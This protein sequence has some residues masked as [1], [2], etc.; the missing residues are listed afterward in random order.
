[1]RLLQSITE[2]VTVGR[3]IINTVRVEAPRAQTQT[4]KPWW[5]QAVEIVRLRQGVGKLDPDEYYQYGLY[6]DRRFTWE[7]KRQFFGRRM[8][9]GLIPILREGWWLGLANDKVI[10]YAFLKGMG[11][12]I[13]EPVA[14]YH[15]WRSCGVTPMLRTPAALADFIRQHRQPFV[16]KP[17][18]GMSGR[19]VSAVREY[20]ATR[21]SVILTNGSAS[22][23]D[24][25]V[26]SL[27]AARDQGGM[28]L[29]E[30]L[31]PHPAIQ[32]RCGERLCTVRLITIV[33]RDG[34]RVLTT[35]WKIATGPSMTDNY[36]RGVNSNLVGPIDLATG[37][38]G[39]TCTGVGHELRYVEQHPDTGKS[40]PGFTLPD[41]QAAVDLCLTATAAI[42][43]LPL[44]AW[45]VALTS[46]GPVL[47]EVNVNGGMTLPQVCVGEGI[48][49]GDFATFLAKFGFPDRH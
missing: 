28:L 33:D 36:C 19:D 12:P 25:F 4:G 14:V 17:V 30:L 20:D 3:E 38:V 8:E 43:K 6:D 9:N 37:V 48:F 21:D 40:L 26:R 1:M 47:L 5:T 45:D 49:R 10:A 29:Q 13:P 42:P 11:F 15:P 7:Q 27:D 32:E 23:V 24:A 34:P 18:F 44:Q 31:A 39:R 46:R 16:A 22:T 41:W 35:L 2:R